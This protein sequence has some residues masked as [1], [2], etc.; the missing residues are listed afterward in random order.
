[1]EDRWLSWEEVSS[2]RE[3]T[4]EEACFAFTR[5]A[6]QVKK[7]LTAYGDG[8][9]YACSE[10]GRYEQVENKGWTT[11][12]WTGQL[13]LLYLQ[14]EDG[15]EKEEMK[16]QALLQVSSFLQRIQE[17]RDVDHHD[18]GFLYSPSCVMAYRL[19]G[20]HAGREAALLAAEQLCSRFQEK[21]AF[22]QAWGEMGA[23]DNYRF[24][25]DCLLNLPLLYWASRES[26]KERYSRQADEHL[27]TAMRYVIREDGSTWH[28]VFMNPETGGFDHGATCQGYTDG[29]AWAR[30]QAWGVYGT[31]LAYERTRK[32]EYK[33]AFEEVARYFLLHLPTDL[34]PF[35]DLS[36]GIWEEGKVEETE[37]EE[38]KEEVREEA[39]EE[40]KVESR[41][42]RR[43]A[44]ETEPRDSS[45]AAIAACGMLC[46][47]NCLAGEEKALWE[48]MARRLLKALA[49]GYL[50]QK[51]EEVKR[52]GILKHA[53][54]SKKSPFNTCTPEG[55]DEFVLWGDYFFL[56]GLLR[57]MDPTFVPCW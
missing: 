53:T 7:N 5:A 57:V 14:E 11:G 25:I 41:E 38:G 31:A 8:F 45:S 9:P 44:G 10:G 12:F 21:G 16:E 19:A 52:G 28:T 43:K 54:Y 17:K 26:G 48:G 2:R 23:R 35:W 20:S 22:L 56:E 40:G 34:C 24:I 6:G 18:M 39:K 13:W 37:G 55:V 30:G 3:I 47:A 33:R 36:F 1:M 4:R 42:A 49:D 46:M 29:S 15:K 27:S 51:G 50:I 32:E